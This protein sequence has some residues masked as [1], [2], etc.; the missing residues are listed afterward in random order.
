MSSKPYRV[1][2]S[3]K[4]LPILSLKKFAY[5]LGVS[6]VKLEDIVNHLVYCY[7]PF[8]KKTANKK[9]IIDKPQGLLKEVQKRINDRILSNIE[10]PE[11]V[12]GGVKGK[13]PADHLQRHIPNPIVVP[14][15]V[16]DC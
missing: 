11:Y 7:D 6:R 10:L 14:I 16:K 3:H 13:K 15:V 1:L 5:C 9:R 4:V 12:V 8:E 2:P